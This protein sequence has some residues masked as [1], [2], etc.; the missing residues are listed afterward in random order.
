MELISIPRTIDPAT[1]PR[2][3]IGKVV[4]VY[5]SNV[6]VGKP[7]VGDVHVI[8]VTKTSVIP[9]NEGLA[10]SKRTPA[11]ASAK[12]ESEVNSP[13]RTA[14]PCNQCWRIVRTR[15]DRSRRPT[16]VAARP[17]P[18]SIMERS[19]APRFVFDPSPSPRILPNPVAVVIRRPAWCD[20]RCPNRAIIRRVAPGSVL[21]EIFVSGD[22]RRNVAR[23]FG[24][25]KLLI[26]RE[27]PLIKIVS[28]RCGVDVVPQRSAVIESG[29]LV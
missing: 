25:I 8:E 29:L 12:T 3:A 11:K 10:E 23:R 27:C 26:S 13:A 18:T 6:N 7:R 15:P 9:G 19:I 1:R 5:V 4:D 24:M 22:I 20:C 21:V 28:C 14:E 2:L 16:P 17:Y